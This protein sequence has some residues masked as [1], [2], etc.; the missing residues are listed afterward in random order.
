MI[1]FFASGIR[2]VFFRFKK[3]LFTV[4][5]ITIG[6]FAFIIIAMTSETASQVINIELSKMGFDCVAVY[7][8][9]S[10]LTP[11]LTNRERKYLEKTDGIQT[12]SPIFVS[13][14]TIISPMGE[15]DAMAWGIDETFSNVMEMKMKYG[16]NIK[17]EDILNKNKVCVITADYAKKY[18]G[19][20]NVIGKYLDTKVSD[21]AMSI[22][23]VGVVEGGMGAIQSIFS[24]FVPIFFYMPYSSVNDSS[25]QSYTQFAIKTEDENIDIGKIIEDMS[26]ETGIGC[27]YQNLS[28]Q[29]KLVSYI[30]SIV[31]TVLSGIAFISLIVAGFSIMTTMY[32]SVGERKR[33]I[34]IKKSVGASRVRLMLDFLWESVFLSL[35]GCFFGWLIAVG[36]MYVVSMIISIP[37]NFDIKFGIFCLIFGTTLGGLF[38]ILPAIKASSLDPIVACRWE[39]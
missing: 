34:G 17:K 22:K 20:E 26:I 23:I 14:A 9:T 33:E 25:W 24:Q 5:S 15:A 37:F 19:R 36:I 28:Q 31:T 30:L 7:S 39:E 3:S 38:G 12:V 1:E 27:S 32:N 2:N 21:R 11:D 6:T 16:R 35:I 10:M 4:I 13:Y 18:F 8:N 29:L